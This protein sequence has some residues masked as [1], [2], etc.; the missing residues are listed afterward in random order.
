M[1]RKL[2]K[3]AEELA[4]ESTDGAFVGLKLLIGTLVGKSSSKS[5]FIAVLVIV[6]LLLLLLM[7][8][9]VVLAGVVVINESEFILMNLFDEAAVSGSKLLTRAKG[10]GG[11]GRLGATGGLGG[12]GGEGG[13]GGCGADCLLNGLNVALNGCHTSEP[14]EVVELILS[15]L[16]IDDVVSI[17]VGRFSEFSN[18]FR[19]ND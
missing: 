15:L 18:E 3:E 8:V 7:L 16:N 9:G 6:L 10:S 19:N 5:V 11:C 4:V 12:E 1:E 13:E 14:A 17:D 2:L